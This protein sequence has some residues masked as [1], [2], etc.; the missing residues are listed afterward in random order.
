MTTFAEIYR[1]RSETYGS[2]AF[3][4][5]YS[6]DTPAK[7]IQK[8][9]ESFLGEYIFEL[10]EYHYE[11]SY[12]NGRLL[13]PNTRETMISKTIKAIDLRK[14][15]RKITTREEAELSGFAKLEKQLSS[16]KEGDV[17][18]WM[19]P[20]GPK[21]EGY[22]DWGFVYLGEVSNNGRLSM[23]ALRVENPK[24]FDYSLFFN[25][26]SNDSFIPLIE[27]DFIAQPLIISNRTIQQISSLVSEFFR[28]RSAQISP[29][30]SDVMQKLSPH[31]EQYLKVVQ[32]GGSKAFEQQ[33]FN[34]VLNYSIDLKDNFES[35]EPMTTL[36]FLTALKQYGYQVPP[37]SGSCGSLGSSN[38]IFNTVSPL[39]RILSPESKTHWDYHD[40]NCVVCN[41]KNAEVGPCNICKNCEKKFD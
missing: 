14:S 10:S 12:E 9:L 3:R 41:K 17:I 32:T 4:L 35:E 2:D 5:E 33:V 6:P 22:G 27:E 28:Q 24:I 21:K 26:I 7:A 40:G 34:M 8:D 20:P 13:D 30:F 36:P 15:E 11:L 38:D 37:L 25:E 16:A 31:I 19:S 23:T 18:I 39:S 29:D 1:S